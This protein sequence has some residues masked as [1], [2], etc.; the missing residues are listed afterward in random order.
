MAITDVVAW[1]GLGLSL[2]SLTWQVT[3]WRLSGVRVHVRAGWRLFTDRNG[4]V[5]K[6]VNTG[7][8]ATTVT[9]ICLSD[10][11]SFVPE[12]DR[13]VFAPES[14][15]WSL[16]H[17]LESDAE[18]VALFPTR[19]VNE[20]AKQRRCRER[21]L[22]P[23]VKVGRREITGRPLGGHWPPAKGALTANLGVQKV[24]S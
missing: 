15:D 7:R 6:V 16:P 24:A 20:F 11:L 21:D 22:V 18:F 5:V 4:V 14:D 23:I 10:P 17:R 1:S 13:L 8:I 9:Y 2:S 12:D 3:S 19:L